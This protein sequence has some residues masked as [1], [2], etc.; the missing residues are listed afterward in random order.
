MYSMASCFDVLWLLWVPTSLSSSSSYLSFSPSFASIFSRCSKTSSRF[1][2][3]KYYLFALYTM[4]LKACIM[5]W[6]ETGATLTWIENQLEEETIF[7]NWI[8]FN[9]LMIYL[10]S[11]SLITLSFYGMEAL[12]T[13]FL[14]SWFHGGGRTSAF[15]AIKILHFMSLLRM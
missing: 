15:Y 12:P 6:S 3:I 1:S 5:F 14:I 11:Y 9:K 4:V 7:S 13:L 8:L 10:H 2:R